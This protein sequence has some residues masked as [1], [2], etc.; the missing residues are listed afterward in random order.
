MWRI[1]KRKQCMPKLKFGSWQQCARSMVLWVA[2]EIITQRE[3]IKWCTQVIHVPISWH[4]TLLLVHTG[5]IRV[6]KGSSRG[7]QQ[8]KMGSPQCHKQGFLLAAEDG[9][10]EW[11]FIQMLGN[12]TQ[13]KGVLLKAHTLSEKLLSI[14]EAAMSWGNSFG[15]V[16]ECGEIWENGK[17]QWV[18]GGQRGQYWGRLEVAGVLIWGH[19]YVNLGV[20]IQ[21][22]T[23]A[24]LACSAACAP[25]SCTQPLLGPSPAHFSCIIMHTEMLFLA[26]DHT[27]S[28]VAL[29]KRFVPIN[30]CRGLL[31]CVCFWSPVLSTMVLSEKPSSE[32]A[33]YSL[34]TW[35]ERIKKMIK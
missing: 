3:L 22:A 29:I 18:V 33:C 17:G 32:Q 26:L 19:E 12:R 20:L 27:A 31:P 7:P 4:G 1:M 9:W 8:P 14:E 28:L 24:Q 11:G 10:D 25:L 30:V 15:V 21:N 34:L 16:L 13:I 5:I 6:L 23:F 2:E 35:W